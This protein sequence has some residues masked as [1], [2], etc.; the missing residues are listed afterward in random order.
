ML[1]EPHEWTESAGE[2]PVM[3]V[4]KKVEVHH[5][6]HGK[7]REQIKRQVKR[8]PVPATK[9]LARRP[10]RVRPHGR[11]HPFSHM[12]LI[13]PSPVHTRRTLLVAG[14]K[15]LSTEA[16]HVYDGQVSMPECNADRS[17]DRQKAL[18]HAQQL[19]REAV[20]SSP[21]MGTPKSG[22]AWGEIVGSTTCS[23]HAVFWASVS[24]LGP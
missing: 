19:R 12:P 7:W 20:C 3:G 24:Y 9:R 22:F 10:M 13:V 4:G 16:V 6:A 21:L 11:I 2:T 14:S 17:T 18:P 8:H 1:H 15:E 23:I 5:Y